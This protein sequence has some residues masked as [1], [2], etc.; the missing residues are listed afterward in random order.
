MCVIQHKTIQNNAL[1]KNTHTITCV[2]SLLNVI[3]SNT[4]LLLNWIDEFY[5]TRFP[6]CYVLSIRCP[7]LLNANLHSP[8]QTNNTL[9]TWQGT[10]PSRFR[11]TCSEALINRWIAKVL[12]TWPY[13]TLPWILCHTIVFLWPDFI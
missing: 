1:Q 6:V 7:V 8:P 13:F 3:C 10:R 12:F 4:T 2:I 11:R 9:H 5:P